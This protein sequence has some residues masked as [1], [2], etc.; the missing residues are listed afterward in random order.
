MSDIKI[1]AD[2]F[3]RFKRVSLPIK[4]I[5]KVPHEETMLRKN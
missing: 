3:N 5:E 4:S 2:R 1:D